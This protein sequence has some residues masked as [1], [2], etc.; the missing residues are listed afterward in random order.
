MEQELG[1]PLPNELMVVFGAHAGGKRML[2]LAARLALR[3]QLYILDCGNR[4]DMYY[5]ARELRTRTNDP[6]MKL[7]NIALSRAFTC[8]QVHMLV[9]QVPPTP[10]VPVLIF[11]LLSTF[12]DESVRVRESMMLFSET[13]ERIEVISRVAPVL[14][15]AKP[16]TSI[17][18][19]RLGLLSELR[20]RATHIWEEGPA[21]LPTEASLQPSLFGENFLRSRG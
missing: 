14:V 16:L 1:F 5:I 11:D 15:S 8:Y 3:G 12:L 18:S 7:K 2:D 9:K 10:G 6:A 19:P 20:K 21:Q 13:M 4:S 17:S